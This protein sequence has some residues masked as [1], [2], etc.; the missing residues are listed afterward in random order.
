MEDPRYAFLHSTMSEE[1]SSSS[2]HKDMQ[3]LEER[4]EMLK[5]VLQD[6][7]DFYFCTC[8]EEKERAI[9]ENIQGK[10]RSWNYIF[11]NDLYGGETPKKVVK[12]EM[13]Q[14]YYLFED[15]NKASTKSY[16][17]IEDLLDELDAFV[18]E[19]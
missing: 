10:T 4:W 3:T 17:M 2:E 18:E 11:D 5:V 1:K 16:P 14:C 13:D 6:A 8:P 19:T 7:Q 15:L 9:I 12:E